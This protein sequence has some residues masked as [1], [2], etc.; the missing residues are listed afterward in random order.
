MKEGDSVEG[1]VYNYDKDQ[2]PIGSSAEL[3]FCT[4]KIKTKTVD[5]PP[6][7]IWT[8]RQ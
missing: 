8:W 3:L 5:N 7:I 1:V 6:S 2:K 4:G